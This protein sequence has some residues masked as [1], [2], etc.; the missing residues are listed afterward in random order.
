MIPGQTFESPSAFSIHIKRLVNPS[1]KADDGWK[2]VKYER[3]YLESFKV[4][5]SKQKFDGGDTAA[6]PEP[7]GT[8]RQRVVPA[9]L[10]DAADVPTGRNGAAAAAGGANGAVRVLVIDWAALLVLCAA[11]RCACVHSIVLLLCIPLCCSCAFTSLLPQPTH[12]SLNCAFTSLLPQPTHHSPN[13]RS[14]DWA[15]V[16]VQPP[17]PP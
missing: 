12:H 10:A 14:T 3:R 17:L 2:T 5:L 4:A 1:R 6:A 7:R 9:H 13:R 16:G 11:L 15:C 8:K